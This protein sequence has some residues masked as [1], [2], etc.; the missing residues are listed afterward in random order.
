[1]CWRRRASTEA[2]IALYR[3]A[4]SINPNNA[5][6]YFNLSQ[7]YTQRFDYHAASDALAH[8]SALN[9]RC[10]APTVPRT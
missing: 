1:M 9:F 7:A 10:C 2:A 4:V 5:A 6:P 3:R 8:A